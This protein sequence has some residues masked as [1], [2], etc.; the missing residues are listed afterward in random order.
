M[1]NYNPLW[2]NE[3][4]KEL[5]K[6]LIS[7]RF[8]LQI[9]DKHE[10]AFNIV[11]T[12]LKLSVSV[13]KI[14]IEDQTRSGSMTW[15]EETCP[16]LHHQISY[17]TLTLPTFAA[18]T[19]RRLLYSQKSAEQRGNTFLLTHGLL[20]CDEAKNKSMFGQRRTMCVRGLGMFRDWVS[21]EHGVSLSSDTSFKVRDVWT[22]PQN[23]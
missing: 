19:Q 16:P 4:F 22:L 12:L 20:W 13:P 15:V 23:G 21:A 5:I 17:F 14:F 7:S 3:P 18:L 6:S 1:L 11:M 2:K 9:K 10:S 8:Y